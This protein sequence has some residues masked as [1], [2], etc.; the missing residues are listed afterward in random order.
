MT[1][2]ALDLGNRQVKMMDEKKLKTFP[3]YF[4]D[5]EELG[6]RETLNALKDGAKTSDYVSSKDPD[7]TYVW[8][9]N[10]EVDN[11]EVIETNR[12]DGRYSATEFA[13]LTDL[14]IAEMAKGN[15]DATEG[16]LKVDIV[17]GMPT[18]DS[19]RESTIKDMLATLGGDH[20]ISIDGKPHNIRVSTVT[21]LPQPVGTLLNEIIDDSYEMI[22]SPLSSATVGITDVGGGTLLID[23]V[24]KLNLDTDTRKQSEHGA[25]SLY[26][27]IIREMNKLG[28]NANRAEIESSL[29]S[30]NSSGAYAWSY[31]GVNEID[32]TEIV[33]K[34]RKRYTRRVISQMN[35]VYKGY[36]RY[37]E[38]LITGGGANLLVR[39]EL[40]KAIPKARII[41]NSESANVRGFY[42]YGMMRAKVNG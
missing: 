22:E 16:I 10:L 11:R 24:Q 14:A 38:I 15:E 8:G 40:L 7:F 34:Q 27:D 21:P 1:L 19:M 5:A 42:K 2:F 39:E 13:V 33:M 20:H 37:Y 35:S 36:D 31:D 18:S 3:S 9:P 6:D 29:R 41:E 30:Q 23:V 32:I 17:T 12:F 25:F 26:D 28:H 4:M